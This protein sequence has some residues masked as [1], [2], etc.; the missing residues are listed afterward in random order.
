M[1]GIPSCGDPLEAVGIATK[2]HAKE[3]FL[4]AARRI[5]HH[6]S[7]GRD[8]DHSRGGAFREVREAR[9]N[10]L[11]D[12]R[13]CRTVFASRRVLRQR[14]PSFLVFA[15]EIDR[16]CVVAAP[17]QLDIEPAIGGDQE[18]RSLWCTEVRLRRAMLS[19]ISPVSPPRSPWGE[20]AA[21]AANLE[22]RAVDFR[23]AIETAGSGSGS[24]D[25]ASPNGVRAAE[26]SH[27]IGPPLAGPQ[28]T[29]GSD[30]ANSRRIASAN[31]R[32]PMWFH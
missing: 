18:S 8:V 29:H 12:D 13:L 28:P 20:S 5:L 31:H 22:S 30:P 23:T 9:R 21:V 3:E 7:G 25:P 1:R 2:G 24:L 27:G 32:R 16:L 15:E 4:E 11:G 19:S 14:H 17:A 10:T 26:S 6:G